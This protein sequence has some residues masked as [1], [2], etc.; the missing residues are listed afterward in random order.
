MTDSNR[1]CKYRIPYTYRGRNIIYKH[2]DILRAARIEKGIHAGGYSE[3]SDADAHWMIDHR[4][5]G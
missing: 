5:K 3:I 1:V 4:K 2:A